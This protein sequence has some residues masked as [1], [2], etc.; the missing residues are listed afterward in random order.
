MEGL[1]LKIVI[2]TFLKVKNKSYNS[3][4]SSVHC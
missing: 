2:K 4:F 3:I 1:I